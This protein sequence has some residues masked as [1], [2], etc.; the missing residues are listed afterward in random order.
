LIQRRRL[1]AA[2]MSELIEERRPAWVVEERLPSAGELTE[3]VSLTLTAD[4]EPE[5]V[6]EAR[7]GE[8][9]WIAGAPLAEVERL[10][11][12]ARD[13][14]ASS[15][16]LGPELALVEPGADEVTVPLGPFDLVGSIDDWQ[17]ALDRE[18]ADPQ[19]AGP[20]TGDG[21]H[22]P[23]WRASVAPS[24][25]STRTSSAATLATG[26]NDERTGVGRAIC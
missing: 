16:Q 4:P 12:D 5:F 17:T 18:K 25:S 20:P 13:G 3:S 1:L 15:L 10:L 11:A 2:A 9:A 23:A 6:F 26:G 22:Q 7:R 24:P 21:R 19:P 8:D 14:L